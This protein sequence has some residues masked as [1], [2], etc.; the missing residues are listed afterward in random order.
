[1]ASSSQKIHHSLREAKMSVYKECSKYAKFWGETGK[2]VHTFL[3]DSTSA[4]V[5]AMD[6]AL[7]R[8]LLAGILDRL[9]IPYDDITVSAEHD[10]VRVDIVSSQANRL[11]GWHG[12]TL[13][14]VQQ[15]LKS[16]LRTAASLD[17][18]PLVIVDVDGY[19]RMQED[20]VKQI[21]EAKADLVRRTGNRI[22]LRPM[23]PYLR[24]VIHLHIAESPAF[25][26]LTT[27]SMG[28]GEYRQI[29]LRLKQERPRTAAQ[30]SEELA[31]VFEDDG[32]ENLDV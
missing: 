15:L 9:G 8:S 20:K 13:Q 21:A 31:P 30:S 27:E 19:R 5:A 23:S 29:V 18:A 4:I 2:F 16:M 1:M 26:D 25:A 22:A 14:A 7:V 32:L 12:E 24:R 3:I 17:R 28:E 10:L 6:H 11:I